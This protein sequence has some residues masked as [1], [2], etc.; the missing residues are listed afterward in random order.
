MPSIRRTLSI[1]CAATLLFTGSLGAQQ[2]AATRVGLTRPDREIARSA[3]L[4]PLQAGRSTGHVKRWPYV[5]TG[6]VIGG[7][8]GTG[9]V[10][11]Q[12]ARTDDAMIVEPFIIG[13]A[14]AGVALGALGGLIVSV[15]VRPGDY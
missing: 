5:V 1:Q 11:R 7:V 3:S 4:T 6:A 8:V 9:L 2:L 12:I 15:V 13:G 14:V 10:V